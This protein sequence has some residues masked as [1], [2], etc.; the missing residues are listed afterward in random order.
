ME[1]SFRTVKDQ[2]ELTL[3]V[4]LSLNTFLKII[5]L[6]F[7]G[8]SQEAKESRRKNTLTYKTYVTTGS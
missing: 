1:G 6:L 7:R 4:D 3:K 8:N 2:F 5:L